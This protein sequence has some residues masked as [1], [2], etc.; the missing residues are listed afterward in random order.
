MHASSPPFFWGLSSKANKLLLQ[1]PTNNL[2]ELKEHL[3]R[4]SVCD[5]SW[6][7]QLNEEKSKHASLAQQNGFGSA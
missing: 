2:D 7:I 3:Q 5:E 4:S 6:P 1:D